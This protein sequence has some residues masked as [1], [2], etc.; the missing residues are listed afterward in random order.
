M[1][2]TT[3][4]SARF[5]P[6]GGIIYTLFISGL[7]LTAAI[8]SGSLTH[9][10]SPTWQDRLG[11]APQDL[12]IP[13]WDRMF[14]SAL[15]TSG[16]KGFWPAFGAMVSLVLIAEWLSGTLRAALAFWISHLGASIGGSLLTWLAVQL[17]RSALLDEIYTLRDVGPSAG[18]FGCMGL[19]VAQLPRPWKHWVGL[20]IMVSLIAGMVYSAHYGPTIDVSAGLAHL[21]AFPLGWSINDVSFLKNPR[22]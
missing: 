18:Y 21:V 1:E 12:I 3:K 11:F 6:P 19:I 22:A 13:H 8:V 14:T 15:V 16:G 2:Q 9:S 5:W 10:L 17:T 20:A 7:L 4:A